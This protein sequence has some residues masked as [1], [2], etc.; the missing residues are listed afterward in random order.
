LKGHDVVNEEFYKRAAALK[1]AEAKREHERNEQLF[2]KFEQSLIEVVGTEL[3]ED[4]KHAARGLATFMMSELLTHWID[5]WDDSGNGLDSGDLIKKIEQMI[6][7][8]KQS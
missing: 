7:L 4:Q 6:G 8:V 1:V 3:R 2:A 5:V